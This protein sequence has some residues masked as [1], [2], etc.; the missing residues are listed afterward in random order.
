MHSNTKDPNNLYEDA[1]DETSRL[2]A[3]SAEVN[4][5]SKEELPWVAATHAKKK[6]CVRE[7]QV[8]AARDIQRV[9]A[10]T[11]V[12]VHLP[13]EVNLERGCQPREEAAAP[14]AGRAIRRGPVRHQQEG[15][16]EWCQSR[17]DCRRTGVAAQGGA[18]I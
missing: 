5:P 4:S 10:P 14:R 9:A 1:P 18:H 3:E 16:P 6:D 13:A 17:R 15:D 12:A 2:T 11:A 8:R 7:G